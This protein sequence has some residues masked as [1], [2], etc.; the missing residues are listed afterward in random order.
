MAEVEEEK[1]TYTIAI[2]VNPSTYYMYMN[3]N[4]PAK[5]LVIAIMR[6][7]LQQLLLNIEELVKTYHIT[8]NVQIMIVDKRQAKEK[9]EQV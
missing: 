4:H 6:N 8:T 3:L 9:Q 1:E 7:L 2:K 5:K